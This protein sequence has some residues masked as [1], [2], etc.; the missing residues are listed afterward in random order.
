MIPKK[1]E[2]LLKQKKVKYEIVLHRKVFTTHDCAQTLHEDIKS[3]AKTLLVKADRDLVFAVIPGN[4]KFDMPKLKKVMNS[5]RKKNEEKPY[6][7]VKLANEADIKK[8]I[9]KKVGALAGFG[10]LY[11]IPAYMDKGIEKS[12]KIFI[13]PGSFTESLKMTPKEYQKIEEPVAGRFSK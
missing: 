9:T 4:K 6:K 3:I 2:K 8:H 5:E 7:K 13:N 12:K 11:K 10:C 1:L